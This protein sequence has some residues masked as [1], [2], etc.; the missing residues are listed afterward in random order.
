M[1][2]GANVEITRGEGS[3][4]DEERD[5]RGNVGRAL[6][7]VQTRRVAVRRS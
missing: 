6:T 3:K 7:R 4:G 5:S 2:T 1:G